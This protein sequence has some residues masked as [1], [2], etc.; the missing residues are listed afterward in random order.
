MGIAIELERDFK[1]ALKQLNDRLQKIEQ[2]ILEI[3]QCK[4]EEKPKPIPTPKKV[5]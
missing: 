5:K 1:P 4:C 2:A 3:S